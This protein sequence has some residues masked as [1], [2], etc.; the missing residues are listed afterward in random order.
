MKRWIRI[1]T[2]VKK[3]IRIHNPEQIKRGPGSE[4]MQQTQQHTS[5]SAVTVSCYAARQYI[6][7]LSDWVQ[8]GTALIPFS[9]PDR[10][11]RG[12]APG[13]AHSTPPPLFDGL[14]FYVKNFPIV[15]HRL[16]VWRPLLDSLDVN[17]TATVG[18]RNRRTN[19][20]LFHVTFG[21]VDRGSGVAQGGQESGYAF[22]RPPNKK[23]RD[24]PA[25]F[26]G[27]LQLRLRNATG[28]RLPP[29]RHMSFLQSEECFVQFHHQLGNP[30][31]F[32]I[33]GKIF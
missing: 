5:D 9:Q 29:L 33:T 15:V 32:I 7:I 30:G 19:E 20:L 24:L 28:G 22:A 18:L 6:I 11:G 4:T 27:V 10:S 17:T 26:E 23:S 2:I 31:I 25:N 1:P 16:G 14:T 12:T 3:W 21:A 13:A 8:D